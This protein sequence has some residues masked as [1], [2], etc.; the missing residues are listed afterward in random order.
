MQSRRYVYKH[1]VKRKMPEI[2]LNGS[3]FG[4]ILSIER[5]YETRGIKLMDTDHYRDENDTTPS[6]GP[7]PGPGDDDDDDDGDDD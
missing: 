7:G 6:F 1:P 5:L 4:Y 2:A 3:S